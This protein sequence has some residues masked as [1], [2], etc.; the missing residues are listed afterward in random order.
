MTFR[1]REKNQD[2]QDATLKIVDVTTNPDILAYEISV[3]DFSSAKRESLGV[4]L[5][6][7]SPE[8][9]SPRIVQD[10]IGEHGMTIVDR[11]DG[12][13]AIKGFDNAGRPN[14][15]RCAKDIA[16]PSRTPQ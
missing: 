11:K 9:L 12:A 7:I 1:V 6:R 15:T 3:T 16:A 5:A 8:H 13:P 2:G 14:L 10:L 4:A